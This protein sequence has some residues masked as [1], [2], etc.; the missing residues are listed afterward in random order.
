MIRGLKVTPLSIIQ[1]EG[2]DVMYAIKK[3]DAGFNDIT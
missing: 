1:T 2:G 3:S